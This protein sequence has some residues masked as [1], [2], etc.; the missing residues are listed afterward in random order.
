MFGK[1]YIASA[2]DVWMRRLAD[3]DAGWFINPGS[4]EEIARILLEIANNRELAV[5]KGVRGREFVRTY[6]WETE[7]R[8]LLELYRGI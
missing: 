8:K 1:P 5:D 3:T 6:N 4:P 7:S 2:F